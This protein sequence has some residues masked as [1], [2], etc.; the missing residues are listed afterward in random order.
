MDAYWAEAQDIGSPEVLRALAADAEVEDA[1]EVLE[2]DAYLDVV[3]RST[4]EAQL[5]GINGIPGFLLGGRL[6]VLGAHPRETFERAF[7]QL[8]GSG[9]VAARPSATRVLPGQPPPLG[10]EL[11]HPLCAERLGEQCDR[12]QVVGLL[13]AQEAARRSRPGSRARRHTARRP[14]RID[15]RRELRAALQAV[16]DQLLVPE[17]RPGLQR[18]RQEHA[19]VLR[20]AALDLGPAEVVQADR[21]PVAVAELALERD[22]L[23]LVPRRLVQVAAACWPVHRGC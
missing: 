7:A 6:L 2:T 13:L 22:R 14:F 4:R 16:R 15:R 12:R 8:G 11:G 10:L 5:M 9:A 21:E 3:Q 19:G 17:R 23:L 1:D 20:P 18:L